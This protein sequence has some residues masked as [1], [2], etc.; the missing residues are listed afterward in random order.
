MN[1]WILRALRGDA[2][3]WW[4]HRELRGRGDIEEAARRERA[5]MRS[6]LDV[7]R[8]ALATRNAYVS[9]GRGGT[10]VHFGRGATLSSYGQFDQMVTA[11]VLVRMGLP[12]IDT[13]PV[14]N[15]WALV[16]LP[17]VA[18][19]I[20]DDDPPWHAMA[21]APLAVYAA[22]AKDLGAIV[23]NVGLRP[24]TPIAA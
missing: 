7:I 22:R 15:P 13:N 12:F 11:Q 2:R 8:K 5:S 14:E 3:G 4:A 23:R 9:T 6:S 1:V 24:A 20:A 21:Y 16:G 19:G 18:V 10:T 17:M